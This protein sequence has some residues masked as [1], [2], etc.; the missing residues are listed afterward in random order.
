MN[1]SAQDKFIT[2]LALPVRFITGLFRHPKMLI[3]LVIVII[4][5]VSLNRCSS[6]TEQQVSIPEY[7]KVAPGVKDAS[8]IVQ[9]ASRTYYVS[10]FS[11]SGGILTLNEYYTYDK[12]EWQ[13]QD[14]NLPIDRKYYGEIQVYER[15]K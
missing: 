2:V 1:E 7:Q 3:V 13:K 9:T 4:A 12:N 15:K 6:S 14:L 11:D 8:H 5:F 10:K